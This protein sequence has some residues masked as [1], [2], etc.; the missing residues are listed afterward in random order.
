MS[1]PFERIAV[2]GVGAITALGPNAVTS[3]R[4]LIGG[5]R[6][7]RGVTLFDVQQHR[8]KLAAEVADLR[9][10]DVAPHGQSDAWSRSDVMALLAA[11]E[12]LESANLAQAESFALAVGASTGGMYEAEAV[13]G[14]MQR[15]EAPQASVRRLLSYPLST[16]AEHIART[17]PGVERAVTL[18]SACSSGANAIVQGVAWLLARRARRVVVGATDGLC[19]LTFTGFNALNA[20]DTGPCRPFDRKRAGLS[21]GEGAAFLVLELEATA[22]ARD[23][24]VLAWLSGWAVAAEAYHITHP[25]PSGATAARLLTAALSRAGLT[26]ADVDYI[27]AHGTGTQHNDAMEARAIHSAFGEAARQVRVSSSKGQVG[28]TL[29]AAGAIEAA[30]TV[31]ALEQGKLPPSGGLEE[32]DPEL[33]LCLVREA[34]SGGELRAAV[35]SS[36]G[37][38]GTGS[39]LVFER[40]DAPVRRR[41]SSARRALVVSGAGTIGALGVLKGVD[42]ARYAAPAGAPAEP[43][44]P[45]GLLDPAR[46]RRFDR[47]AALVSLGTRSALESAALDPA[48]VGLVSGTAFGSVERSVEFL[49][50]AAERGPRLASPAEFPHL[51]PSA[52][53]GNASIYLGLTGPVLGVSD[54]S[55]SGEAAAAVAASWVELGLADAMVAGSAEPWDAVVAGVLGPIVESS[56]PEGRGEGAGFVV[57]EAGEAARARDARPLAALQFYGES[58]LD[59]PRLPAGLPPP[60]AQRVRVLFA[61]EE[62]VMHSVLEATDWAKVPRHRVATAAGTHDA[63]GAF[64][65]AAA[66]ALVGTGAADQVLAL[67][68][69]RGHAYAFLLGCAEAA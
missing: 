28:H 41:A 50:R 14:S 33:D 63:L 13:L 2:T 61:G 1:D 51:V 22:R 39:V 36:F 66:A 56:T 35:S 20:T 58:W 34:D 40:H 17:L 18:C 64:A 25:E 24:R 19:A 69:A 16:T 9:V 67:G 55:T 30:F 59:P 37:F 43:I 65:L 10:A 8:S 29:A 15:G 53:A 44:D 54:L 38:G 12:A 21:L 27:N 31:L 11:R 62:A 47:A 52:P 3:F 42:N 6:G 49:K 57:I 26:P 5:E 68:I 7:F 48:R 46:S 4:R 60:G 32:P 23:A 45:L